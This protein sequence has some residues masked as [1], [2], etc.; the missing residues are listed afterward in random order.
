LG[1]NTCAK[2]DKLCNRNSK[3]V[4]YQIRETTNLELHVTCLKYPVLGDI[5]NSTYTETPVQEFN[6]HVGMEQTTK[7]G[8]KLNQIEA[9]TAFGRLMTGSTWR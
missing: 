4:S 1:R 9:D 8:K 2:S 6:S 3:N 7:W 5:H